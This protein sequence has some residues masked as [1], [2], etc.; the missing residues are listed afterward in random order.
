MT[1]EH[2]PTPWRVG[3]YA[4]VV[5]ADGYVVADGSGVHILDGRPDDA[6]HWNY[7]D[8]SARDID[9][10]EE[11]ANAAF[12]VEAVN[13][14]ERLQHVNDELVKA[15]EDDAHARHTLSRHGNGWALFD[16]CQHE[17]CVRIR[18]LIALARARGEAVQTA[19]EEG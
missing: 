15:L 2:T 9:E 7:E 4:L 8:G 5:G 3:D 19:G 10:A 17:H 11:V 1:Q 6:P 18:A 12:I 16:T 14:Y 13:N